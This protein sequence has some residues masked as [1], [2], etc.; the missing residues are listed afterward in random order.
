VLIWKVRFGQMGG[1][2][3]TAR[4]VRA[5]D[6][7][8]GTAVMRVWRERLPE[9][10]VFELD[11]RVGH[12]PPLECPQDV[13]AAYRSFRRGLAQEVDGVRMREI[14]AVTQQE[15][16]SLSRSEAAQNL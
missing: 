10:P 9:A 1:S 3:N 4:L 13:I 6:P 8:S 5:Y 2:A 7:I 15:P 14:P 12:Y 16:K 11:P